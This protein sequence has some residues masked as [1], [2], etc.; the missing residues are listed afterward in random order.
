MEGWGLGHCWELCLDLWL[1]S[2]LHWR[3]HVLCCLGMLR[4]ARMSGGVE[5]VLRGDLA[6]AKLVL[7]LGMMFAAEQAATPSRPSNDREEGVAIPSRTHAGLSW[8]ERS[9][10]LRPVCSSRR[11]NMRESV[12]LLP[13]V[14]WP[15]AHAGVMLNP[16]T[17]ERSSC[18]N[19]FDAKTNG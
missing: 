18:S 2:R 17:K 14:A 16:S 13:L 4:P 5:V 9:Q 8:L 1:G 3:L 10:H 12:L 6:A 7:S 11:S 19:D 15:R